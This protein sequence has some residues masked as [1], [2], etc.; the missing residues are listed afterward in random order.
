VL[1]VDVDRI[2]GGLRVSGQGIQGFLVERYFRHRPRRGIHLGCYGPEKTFDFPFHF[3]DINVTHHRNGLKIGAVPIIV[4]F[5]QGLGF[6]IFDH[7]KVANHI[8]YGIFRIL[9]QYRENLLL[10][11]EVGIAPGAPLFR[12]DSPLQVDLLVGE[13]Q[14]IRPIVEDQQA[15]VYQPGVGDRHVAQVVHGLVL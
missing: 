9:E 8:A 13:Q 3:V 7:V 14:E 2:G 1:D 12:D 6:K 10:H 11:P 4:K 15:G 5:P